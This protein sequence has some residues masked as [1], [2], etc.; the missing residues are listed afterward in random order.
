M[1][2]SK[3]KL[4][5][6]DIISKMNVI[7]DT[8]IWISFLFGKQLQSVASVFDNADIKV[9]V[10]PEQVAEIQSVLS[11]PKISEHISR[12]SIDAMWEL[13]RT[14]CYPIED[15][16]AVESSVRD[17]KDAYLLSMAEAIPANVIVTGDKDLLVLRRHGNTAI[18]TY[19]EFS[20]LLSGIRYKA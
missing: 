6:F 1:K 4:M 18:M 20:M 13:M 8:N 3:Q 12:E 11:R 15:Y 2:K 17:V 5:P 7:L 9:Y 14:R 16:P 10:S 19:Q